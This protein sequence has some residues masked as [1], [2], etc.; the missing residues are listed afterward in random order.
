M[1]EK[2]TKIAVLMATHNGMRWIAEQIDSIL[3]QKD[4]QIKL[5][6]SDDK[7]TDGT[8]EWLKTLAKKDS[9]I[10][11][12]PSL[13]SY[14]S[15]GKNFYRLILEA[16]IGG[17][18]YIALADQDD[19]W[20]KDKLKKQIN[21]LVKH[22]A[23]GVSSNVVAFWQ[24][25]S[26]SLAIKDSTMRRLDFLFESPGPGSTFV[27]SPW[28]FNRI[29]ILLTDPNGDANQVEFHDW[30]IYAVC[31][32][33]GKKWHIYNAPLVRY[34]QHDKNAV[35]VNF[36]LKAINYRFKRIVN[37]WYRSEVAKIAMLSQKLSQDAYVLASCETIL[38]QRLYA[39]YKLLKLMPEARRK[40]MDCFILTIA[41]LFFLF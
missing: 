22:S 6:I 9:R 41:S 24:D 4:V 23:C 14:G 34:R 19:V 12:L 15:A 38:S 25:G 3:R 30:L 27:L 11:L 2:V 35:G 28:L 17:C 31:R 18:D 33:L 32:A 16:D 39:R 1:V 21:A 5:I 26:R 36:G 7:S 20:L 13:R 40:S 29:R 10:V 8:L 37:G